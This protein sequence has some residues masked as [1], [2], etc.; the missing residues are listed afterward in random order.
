MLSFLILK[1][2]CNTYVR[3]RRKLEKYRDV[4]DPC[5]LFVCG[6]TSHHHISNLKGMHVLAATDRCETATRMT[7]FTA[8]DLKIATHFTFLKNQTFQN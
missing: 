5:M 2:A 8:P 7:M 4:E 6:R 1:V 3:R